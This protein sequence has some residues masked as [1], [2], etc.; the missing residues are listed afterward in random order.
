MNKNNKEKV[1]FCRYKS[2]WKIAINNYFNAINCCKKK[3]KIKNQGELNREKIDYLCLQEAKIQRYS[4]ITVVFC[5]MTLESYI[6][7]YGITNFSTSYFRNYLDR[8]D[9]K[10]KWIII[11]NL[12]T[13][14]QLDTDSEA[15]ELFSETLKIRNKIIHDKTKVIDTSKLFNYDWITEDYA[16]DS[17]N[18]VNEMFIELEKIDPEV[19]I[20]WLESVKEDPYA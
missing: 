16:K 9:L 7:E 17:I 13:G 10:S 6:N 8:L 1:P 19:D 15:F 2:F 5:I 11:P 20:D 3:N 14:L 12:K 4:M 18:A